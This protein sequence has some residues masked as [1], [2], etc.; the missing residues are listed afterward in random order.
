MNV[1]NFSK[2]SILAI[3]AAVSMLVGIVGGTAVKIITA[4]AQTP[5]VTPAV[6]NPSPS[7]VDNGGQKK[8]KSN[9]DPAHEA[10]E[11][12]EREAQEDAG[13]FPTAK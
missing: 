6:V 10:K 7:S 8:F 1:K 3:I 4:N 11:S 9:E 2:K 12:P 5:T 13:Q